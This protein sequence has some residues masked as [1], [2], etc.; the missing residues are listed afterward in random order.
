MYKNIFLKNMLF[1]HKLILL[2]DM[3]YF[4]K[5]AVSFVTELYCLG[6]PLHLY[7]AVHTVSDL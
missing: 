5:M 6:L 2:I 1:I 3:S 7:S 4:P